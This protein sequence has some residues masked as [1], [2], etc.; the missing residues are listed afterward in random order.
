[1]IYHIPFVKKLY[2]SYKLFKLNTETTFS[3]ISHRNRNSIDIDN[4]IDTENIQEPTTPSVP[5]KPRGN[6]LG[7]PQIRWVSFTIRLC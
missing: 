6:Q 1:M 3:T 7:M 4:P 2:L 5:H